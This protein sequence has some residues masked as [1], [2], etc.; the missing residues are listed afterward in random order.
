[1]LYY[2]W[3]KYLWKIN[4]FK[5]VNFK[6][7]IYLISHHICCQGCWRNKRKIEMRWWTK[8]LTKSEVMRW[9][10]KA[11]DYLCNISLTREEK[12]RL[13]EREVSLK[14]KKKKPVLSSQPTKY[15]CKIWRREKCAGVD[16]SIVKDSR[17]TDHKCVWCVWW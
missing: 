15:R 13:E 16:Q 10:T 5:I 11:P 17:R 3:V 4:K 12:E 9:M 8:S 14:K 2:I 7:I 6:R 1:M